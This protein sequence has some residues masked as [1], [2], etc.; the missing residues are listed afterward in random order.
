MDYQQRIAARDY[1][2]IV[3][4]NGSKES[5]SDSYFRNLRG[6]FRYFYIEHASPSPAH[7]INFGIQQSHGK[8]LGVMIDGARIASPGL[9][10][11]A[12]GAF[13]AFHNPV[14]TALAWH[15][16][17][18]IHRQAIKKYGYSQEKED[19]LIQSINWPEDGYRLFEIST[20]AGSSRE[21]WFAPK[22]ESSSLFMSRKNFEYLGGYDERFDQ[23]GGGLVNIDT[24]IRACEIPDS[25]LVMLLGEGT[26][27]QMHGGAMTGAD[28]KQSKKK[29]QAWLAQYAAI[30]N[31]SI[32][33]P[34]KNPHYI[35]HV[36]SQALRTI[37]F[38][39]ENALKQLEIPAVKMF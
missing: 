19:Q 32:V 18:G 7:A 23:P 1:E 37:Q 33:A 15:L 13:R 28:E 17:P 34:A 3:V 8:Y 22:T 10:Q 9:L 25:D 35:G 26:F 14:V 12:L 29:L 4:D 5:L 20:L 11:Y 27:H 21:G 30:R 31:K 2:I 36:P 6:N 16:G 24:Y 39:A 38:S